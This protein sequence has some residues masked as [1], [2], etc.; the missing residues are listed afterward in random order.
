MYTG[1]VYVG[2]KMGME[3]TTPGPRTFNI[4]QGRGL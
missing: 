1:R 3:F 2:N 4:K